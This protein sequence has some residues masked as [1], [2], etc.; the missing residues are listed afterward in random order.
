[1]DRL[2]S[3]PTDKKDIKVFVSQSMQHST[4]EKVMKERQIILCYLMTLY[5]GYNFK[6]INQYSLKDKEEWKDK[7]LRGRRWACLGR[8]IE[9]MA[10]ADLIVFMQDAIMPGSNAPGCSVEWQVAQAYMEEYPGDYSITT[11]KILRDEI[12]IRKNVVKESFNTILNH[13]IAADFDK[14]YA[15]FRELISVVMEQTELV[16]NEFEWNDNAR[17]YYGDMVDDDYIIS[18][19]L[20]K[21]FVLYDGTKDLGNIFAFTFESKTTDPES[22]NPYITIRSIDTDEHTGVYI[23]GSNFSDDDKHI[24]VFKALTEYVELKKEDIKEFNEVIP[25]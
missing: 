3:L 20:S 7:S 25:S 22:A 5:P 11:D 1:M 4:A 21:D 24:N 12:H 8:S 9:M 2:P 6:L 17:V 23:D 18:V 15:F 13:I 14:Y 16:D 19:E 10:D